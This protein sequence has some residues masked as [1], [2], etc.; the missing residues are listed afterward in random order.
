MYHY[1]FF[2]DQGE[3]V[4]CGGDNFALFCDNFLKFS[5]N[6]YYEQIYNI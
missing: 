5:T 2:S 4:G 1:P 6:A 3:T